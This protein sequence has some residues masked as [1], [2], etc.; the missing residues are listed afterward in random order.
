MPVLLVA[1]LMEDLTGW[2]TAFVTGLAE[3]GFRVIRFDNRDV[4]R[5]SSMS[6]SPPSLA[7][8]FFARPRPDAYTLEDMAA[9]AVGL[10]DHLGIRRAHVIGRSMGGMIAQA[11]AAE[12][13]GRVLTLTSFYSTTGNRRV[14]KAALSTKVKLIAKPPTTLDGYIARHLDLVAHLAGRDHPYD[15][16]DEITHARAA[17]RR[18]T[19][20]A[21]RAGAA[22][23]IQA[24]AASGD[25][26]PRLRTIRVPTLVINGDRDLIVHPSGGTATARAIPGAR[27]IV[28]PGM[29]H[30]LPPSLIDIVLGHI[31][32]HTRQG[33]AS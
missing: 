18:A 9:D 31:T 33:A 29:G 32:W 8:Q 14:G 1:G 11:I 21:G 13:P 23:Q 17:W 20:N 4:G 6:A 28:I 15:E 16:A 27:H 12:H 3:R 22:R 10:L 2:P 26:T 30:H 7:R 19:G 24:I 5:S 25:R